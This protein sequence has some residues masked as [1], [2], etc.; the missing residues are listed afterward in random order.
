MTLNEQLH[1]WMDE[2]L[3]YP[4][5]SPQRRVLANKIVRSIQRSGKLWKASGEDA[6]FYEDALMMTWKY[7]WRNL[8]EAETAQKGAFC[9]PDCN[10][11]AR[12]NAYL[13]KRVQDLAVKAKEEAKRKAKPIQDQDSGEWI[14]P[15]NND[16]SEN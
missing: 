11:M 5:G 9:E 2:G 15:M 4:S 8:W 13:Q 16:L 12:L 14:D 3:S 6:A 10:V 7:F 1:R